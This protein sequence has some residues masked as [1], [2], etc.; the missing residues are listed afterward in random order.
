MQFF[1]IVFTNK[2]KH[3][4]E[5]KHNIPNLTLFYGFQRKVW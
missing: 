2:F 5:Y 1:G 3:D 4:F